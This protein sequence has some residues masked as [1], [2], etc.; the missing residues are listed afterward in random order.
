MLGQ[1][2][3]SPCGPF[4]KGYV[5]AVP[6]FIPALEGIDTETGSVIIYSGLNI[7]LGLTLQANVI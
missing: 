3:L 5:T 6:L 7:L 2:L 1:S 4:D